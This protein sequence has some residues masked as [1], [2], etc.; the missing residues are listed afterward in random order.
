[1]KCKN[2]QNKGSC[3]K[4]MELSDRSHL[5]GVTLCAGVSVGGQL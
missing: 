4:P 5:G 2:K 3:L 1:M